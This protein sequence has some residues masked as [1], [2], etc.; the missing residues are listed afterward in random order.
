MNVV[1]GEHRFKR[2]FRRTRTQGA[3]P[4]MVRISPILSPQKEVTMSRRR[5]QKLNEDVEESEESTLNSPTLTKNMDEKKGDESKE[6]GD[7]EEGPAE[8]A[9]ETIQD[10]E[11]QVPN[12]EAKVPK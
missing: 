3:T 7:E 11:T 1:Q 10:M 5:K 2:V 8:T 9:T 12:L 4:N 6:K